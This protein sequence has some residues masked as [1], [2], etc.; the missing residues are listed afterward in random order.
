M[1]IEGFKRISEEEYQLISADIQEDNRPVY[2]GWT[3]TSTETIV[4]WC[5]LQKRF[6]YEWA[7]GQPFIYTTYWVNVNLGEEIKKRMAA[8][9]A[10]RRF[11][12]EFDAI[13]AKQAQNG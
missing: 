7:L 4:V 11:K 5:Y 13:A 3:M 8:K 2:S 10:N 6:T 12:P 1:E 9:K